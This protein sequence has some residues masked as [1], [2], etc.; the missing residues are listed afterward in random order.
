MPRSW[1]R[2]PLYACAGVM[3][4]CPKRDS[5]IRNQGICISA[6]Q[7]ETCITVQLD[8]STLITLWL[9]SW[10]F[11]W[12]SLTHISWQIWGKL[13]LHVPRQLL[14]CDRLMRASMNIHELLASLYCPQSMKIST[15]RQWQRR[16][17]PQNGRLTRYCSE[18]RRARPSICFRSL[19][20]HD[21]RHKTARYDWMH[22]RGYSYGGGVIHIG[23]RTPTCK[24]GHATSKVG[25]SSSGSN[26]APLGLDEGGRARKRFTANWK[27]KQQ[28]EKGDGGWTWDLSWQSRFLGAFAI[29]SGWKLSGR[30]LFL[31]LQGNGRRWLCTTQS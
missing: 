23:A 22:G 21:T 27:W 31:M 15:T 30:Q 29:N 11:A 28:C 24:C 12:K 20:R 1:P 6:E 8:L 14:S 25:S 26:S 5:E 10:I 13:R 18:T 7:H 4:S 16:E 3:G 17:N 2:F 19:L 9:N